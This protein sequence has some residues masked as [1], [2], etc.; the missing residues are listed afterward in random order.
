[1]ELEATP[2]ILVGYRAAATLPWGANRMG[3]LT[4]Q[5]GEEYVITSDCSSTDVP[6]KRAPKRGP[7]ASYQVWTGDTWSPAK[8]DAMSFGTLDEA[9]EYVRANYRR[10][11]SR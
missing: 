11:S 7:S 2:G 10:L 8:T 1:L 4:L 3:I 9:D 6:S 5:Q